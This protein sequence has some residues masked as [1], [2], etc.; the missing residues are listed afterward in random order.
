VGRTTATTQDRLFR[1]G[2]K[3]K[4][5]GRF[6]YSATQSRPVRCK[7]NLLKTNKDVQGKDKRSL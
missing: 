6:G 2:R 7:H 5:E 3:S 4:D 1:N